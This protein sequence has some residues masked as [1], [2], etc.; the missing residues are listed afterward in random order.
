MS[1]FATYPT[2]RGTVDIPQGLRITLAI[3]QRNAPRYF[4]EPEENI[5]SKIVLIMIITLHKNNRTL[6][7]MDGYGDNFIHA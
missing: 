7:A 6:E 4:T 2:T 3:P 5:A 1:V